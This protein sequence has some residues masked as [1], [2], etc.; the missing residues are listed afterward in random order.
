[1]HTVRKMI[2]DSY[3]AVFG[4]LVTGVLVLFVYV[5]RA[6][7]VTPQATQT[8]GCVVLTPTRLL[9]R[10]ERIVTVERCDTF[11]KEPEWAMCWAE[12]VD[13]NSE[14]TRI[15]FMADKS[16]PQGKQIRVTVEE[17]P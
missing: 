9:Y 2:R 13:Y 15:Y 10:S 8:N 7:K 3:S 14:H 1:M 4:I 11:Q 6:S 5:H 16:W 17:M 12:S